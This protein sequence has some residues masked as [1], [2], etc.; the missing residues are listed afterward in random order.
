MQ[1]ES[2]WING[3]TSSIS[4]RHAVHVSVYVIVQEQM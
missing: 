1:H 3:E 4:E 2:D